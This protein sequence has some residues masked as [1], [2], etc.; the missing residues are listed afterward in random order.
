M[1]T[2]PTA[3]QAAAGRSTDERPSVRH[4]AP[5]VAPR[6]VVVVVAVVLASLAGVYLLFELKR[7]VVWLLVAI[8]FAGV[9]EPA[10]SWVERH[11]PRRGVAVGLVSGALVVALFGLAILFA[12]P[13]ISESVQFAQNLPETVER[14]RNAPVVRDLADRF[15][16]QETIGNVGDQ[17]PQQLMGLSGPVLSIFATIG[18][19]IVGGITIFVLMV[20]LLLYGPRFVKTGEIAVVPEQHRSVIATIAD[21]S[22]HAVSGWVAGNVLTSGIAGLVALI[23]FLLIGLPY[24]SLLALWVF[25][26]DLIPLVG[27]TLGALPAIIVAFMH[28]PTAGIVV[29]VFFIVY[30]Q[31]ENHALQ[32]LVYGKT[33]RLNPFIVLLAVIVGVELAGFVGALLAL[34][35]AGVVQVTI[36]E[37]A[38]DRLEAISDELDESESA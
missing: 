25:V 4:W 3:P 37:L 2:E 7:L 8:F 26:A 17:V 9:L 13:I 34:P 23:P 22:M 14:I 5:H 18:Q 11:G 24:A 31:V 15:N 1:R 29:T 27:A 30:Q 19:V 28:S 12:R 10:V 35:V 36:E 20:F 32:P 33:I 6:D 16:V 21:R 38:S